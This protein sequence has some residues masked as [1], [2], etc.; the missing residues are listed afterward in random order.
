MKKIFTLAL[1]TLMAGNMMA[2]MH[3]VLKFA[4]A[5]TANVLNQNVANASDTVQF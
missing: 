5:S 1:A 2:Q 3:G 4:G